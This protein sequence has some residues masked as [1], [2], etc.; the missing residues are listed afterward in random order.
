MHF[1]V[2]PCRRSLL[3]FLL[4]V[5]LIFSIILCLSVTFDEARGGVC[6]VGPNPEWTSP[7]KQEWETICSNQQAILTKASMDKNIGTTRV[8]RKQFLEEVLL[9]PKYKPVIET[10]GVHK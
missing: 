4:K 7:E 9:N 10:K 1:S 2:P 6:S 3:Y 8:I 5:S